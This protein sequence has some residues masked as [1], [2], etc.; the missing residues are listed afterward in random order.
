MSTC[1]SAP[2]AHRIAILMSPMGRFLQCRDCHLTLGF[3]VGSQYNAIAKQFGSH[4]CGGAAVRSKV[5]EPM[6]L[7]EGV[8]AR[9]ELA[10]RKH[11]TPE[12]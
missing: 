2:S 3:P 1:S 11:R 8:P 10:N 5:D 4:V 7:I 9:P 12:N 6:V